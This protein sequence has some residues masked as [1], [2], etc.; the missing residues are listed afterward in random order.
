MEFGDHSAELWRAKGERFANNNP[1]GPSHCYSRM[2]QERGR[3]G[4][5]RF[6]YRIVLPIA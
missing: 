5:G 1:P 2:L 6:V 4:T 3:Y